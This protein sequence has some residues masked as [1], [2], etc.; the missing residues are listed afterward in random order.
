MNRE[1]LEG[2]ISHEMSHIRN[3]DIRYMM[4]VAVMVGMTVIISEIMLRSF[5][6]GGGRR[7][8]KEGGNVVFIIIG[9]I[10]AILAP[11]FAQLIQLAISRK[12]EYLADASG[13]MLTRN[14]NGLASALKKLKDY[15]GGPMKSASKATAHLFISNP[16]KNAS[17]LFSTHPDISDRIKKLES[18]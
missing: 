17:S 14:P 16:F 11:I 9:L 12:R 13:A 8:D 3:F 15:K 1:E 4:I 5:I 7:D 18:M 2:V 6:F 10:L